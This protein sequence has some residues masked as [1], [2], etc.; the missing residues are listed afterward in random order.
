M[1]HPIS[2]EPAL[3]SEIN[4]SKPGAILFIQDSDEN[5]LWL[6]K[7]VQKVYQ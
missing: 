7:I 5:I 3:Q 6:S 2:V 4:F 1:E